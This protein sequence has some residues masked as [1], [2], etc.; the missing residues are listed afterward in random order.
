MTNNEVKEFCEKHCLTIDQ[1]YGRK[2]IKGDLILNY[3][4]VLPEGFKPTVEGALY[5][6]SITELPKGFNPTVG[7]YLN[8]NSITELPEDFNPTVGGD[9]NLSSI[10]EIPEGFNPIVG[11]NLELRSVT[12]LPEVF[13]PTI[14]GSLYLNS[15]K[16]IPEGFNPIV[17]IDLI[18]SSL[19]EL[20]KGFNPIVGDYLNL[21]SVT[22]LPDIF[23]PTVG[24]SLDLSSITELPEDFNPIIGGS[25]HLSSVKELPKDFNPTVGGSI[26][27]NNTY[28]A[29]N[30]ELPILSWQDG[31]YIKVDGI[32][33]EVVHKKGN[34]YKCKYLH[35]EKYFYVVT[36][37]NK[38]YAH[39]KTIKEA[40]E[41]L[42]YKLSKR[43]KYKYKNL[44][45]DSVLKHDEAVICYRIITGACRF[46]TNDFLNNVLG[47]NTKESYT[48]REIIKLTE[49]KYGNTKFKEFFNV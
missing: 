42:L 45:I 6:S 5:L 39:G 7:G 21:R 23:N 13:N 48:I 11:W 15:V 30:Y 1:F 16:E 20:P 24:G 28:R 36:D 10:T 29:I 4:K 9:L 12:K 49:N 26:Y 8:L 2:V 32:L 47:E 34:Y 44:T 31:K 3:I 27:Y 46:G 43:N 19:T 17:S 40:Q 22:K 41:D 18:L 37:G 35:S 33:S 14:G 38:T 25:L